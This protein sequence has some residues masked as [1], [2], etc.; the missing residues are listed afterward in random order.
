MEI[1]TH[2]ILKS[3]L[4]NRIINIRPNLQL[5]QP[6]PQSLNN[7]LPLPP[8]LLPF[9][10]LP[11]PITSFLYRDY[12]LADPFYFLNFALA[13]RGENLARFLEA[14]VGQLGEGDLGG[15]GEGCAAPT[16]G[17]GVDAFGF[18]ESTFAAGRVDQFGVEVWW[19]G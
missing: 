9:L 15:A 2:P 3:L 14:L 12:A 1:H 8:P 4:N 11:H 10:A 17:D 7:I 6:L 16:R 18:E 19:F 5:L 13:V